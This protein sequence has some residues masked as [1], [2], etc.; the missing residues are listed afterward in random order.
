M[1]EKDKMLTG[2]LYCGIDNALMKDKATARK[3][4]SRYNESI[5]DNKLRESILSELFAKVGSNPIIK[6]PFKCDYGYNIYVGENFF[7]NFD[8]VFLDA[9]KIIIGNNCKIGPKT[10][11]FAVTHPI[12]S[13]T[14][15]DNINIP[16]DVIIGDDVW[17]GG[18]AIIL[19]GINIG[20]SSIIGAG[21]V[22]TK[23]VPPHCVVAGNPAKII[24]RDI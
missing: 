24:K 1:N 21:S 4:C 14:R 15:A 13:K 7:A 11:I 23:D 20:S 9:G 8:C 17:I 16:K 2:Q 10:M 22:V 5:E 3:I 6:P 19:P 18:G 12:D